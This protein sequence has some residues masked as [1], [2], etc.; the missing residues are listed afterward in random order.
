S[1]LHEGN[2]QPISRLL[3]TPS[4]DADWEHARRILHEELGVVDV[5]SGLHELPGMLEKMANAVER[6]KAR[7]NERGARIME[8]YAEVHVAAKHDPFVRQTWEETRRL[9]QE[10]DD[11]LSRLA[12]PRTRSNGHLQPQPILEELTVGI[13]Q[14]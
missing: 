12:C 14:R 1:A 3:A 9:Q 11:L 2:E 5:V 10:I 8:D 7:D 13:S 6:S 4:G